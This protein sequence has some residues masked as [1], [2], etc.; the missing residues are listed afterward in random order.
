MRLLPLIP[1]VILILVGQAALDAMPAVVAVREGGMGL[2]SALILAQVIQGAALALGA[3][4]AAYFID[5]R[6]GP[7]A[8]LAGSLLFY[9]GLF[10]VGLQPMGALAWVLVAQGA[11]GAGFGIIL[12]ASFAAAA[13]MGAS[14]RLFA[15][16]LLLLAP[17][18]ARGVIGFMYL[19]GTLAL[20]LAGGVA[21]GVAVVVARLPGIGRA[22]S[23]DHITA[24]A[25]GLRPRSRRIAVLGG[26]MVAVGVLLALVGADPSRVSAALLAGPVGIGGLEGL[27]DL[28]AGMLA[29]GLGLVVVGAWLLVARQTAGRTFLAVPAIAL[30]AFAGSGMVAALS[31]AILT[32]TAVP[33]ERTVSPVGVAAVGGSALG[34][35]LGAA[36]LARG[37]RPRVVA[38]TGCALLA[39]A[40][41]VGLAIVLAPSDELRTLV[42][43]A[44][45]ALL[46]VAGGAA[47]SALRLVL[48]RVVVHQRGLAA[49]AGVVAASFGSMLGS[50]IGNGE[51]VRLVAGQPAETSVG[52]LALAATAVTAV[53]VAWFVAPMEG[54]RLPLTRGGASAGGHR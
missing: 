16:L 50:M 1:Y 41:A 48:A 52:L 8:L 54:D 18:A 25:D 2:G 12:T 32:G 4:A 14:V 23:S 9:A 29:G 6:N 17:L 22:H 26:L 37:G 11:A 43:L 35:V 21:V 53:A 49:A 19:G 38:T 3:A 27:D 15:I 31:F 46:G 36:W 51:G 13:A 44:A 33:G 39:C 10:A 5:R 47:A 20:T 45:V 34:V 42:P 28:R 7:V 24:M 30:A 40:T